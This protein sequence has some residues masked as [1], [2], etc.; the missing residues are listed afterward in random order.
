MK[1]KELINQLLVYPVD[2]DVVARRE[3]EIFNFELNEMKLEGRPLHII[4]I[5]V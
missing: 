5:E 1:V 4:T 3:G 2:Y